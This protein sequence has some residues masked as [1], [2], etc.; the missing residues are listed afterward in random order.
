MTRLS[1]SRRTL[2]VRGIVPSTTM[3]PAMV[4]AF[5]TLNVFRTSAR[6]WKTS[7]NFGSR[8]PVMAAF[9]SSTRL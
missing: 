6:P 4:P 8:R 3:H 5:G 7:W 2:A 1:R 9:N